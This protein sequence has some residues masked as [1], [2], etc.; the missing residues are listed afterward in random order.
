MHPLK[1]SIQA[2]E[3]LLAEIKEAVKRQNTLIKIFH[4]YE[5]DKEGIKEGCGDVNMRRAERQIQQI[6]YAFDLIKAE[7]K[8]QKF[9]VV[10]AGKDLVKIWHPILEEMDVQKGMVKIDQKYQEIQVNANV[11]LLVPLTF[12]NALQ[13]CQQT[14]KAGLKRG[15]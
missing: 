3:K 11:D 5:T 15:K 14:I 7:K 13:N 9:L 10:S 8:M 12:S 1:L 2:H 6:E 4:R